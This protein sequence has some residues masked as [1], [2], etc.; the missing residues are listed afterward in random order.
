MEDDIDIETKKE[1]MKKW[2][3]QIK[4]QNLSGLINQD[5]PS[6]LNLGMITE[7]TE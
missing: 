6:D 2:K 7:M 3:I 1:N 5:K 4:R